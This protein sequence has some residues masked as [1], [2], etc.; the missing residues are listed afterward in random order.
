VIIGLASVRDNAGVIEATLRH[1]LAHG[2]DRILLIDHKSQDGTSD[3]LARLAAETGR[4]EITRR[5]DRYYDHGVWVTALLSRAETF[6]PT[7]IVPF[8][9][10]EIIVP[11][12]RPT[13][14]EE[15]AACRTPAILAAKRWPH[16]SLNRRAADP[17]PHR[18]V[19]F[20]WQPGAVIAIGAH[21]VGG[22]PGPILENRIA[23]RER[24]YLSERHFI[25]KTRQHL[26]SRSPRHGPGTNAQ[27]LARR[28]MSREQLVAMYRAWVIG[29]SAV[30]DPIPLR[31]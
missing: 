27:Y 24:L 31:R 26:E 6:A 1:L 22:H 10:D 5:E 11:L 20:S 12:T 15:F 28:E 4:L 14:A 17:L 30:Y 2:V 18:K 7:W 16:A 29:A 13:L 25:R 8:D 23:I 9:A 19:V 3:I 21:S